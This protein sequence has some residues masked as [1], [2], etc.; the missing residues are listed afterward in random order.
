MGPTRRRPPSSW[1]RKSS[2]RATG[3]P[4]ARSRAPEARSRAPEARRVRRAAGVQGGGTARRRS[5]RGSSEGTARGLEATAVRLY[6]CSAQADE[7]QVVSRGR[8]AKAGEEERTGRRTGGWPPV[9]RRQLARRTLLVYLLERR[10]RQSVRVRMRPGRRRRRRRLRLVR[11]DAYDGGSVLVVAS[12]LAARTRRRRRRARRGRRR[13]RRV[14]PAA[15]R[16]GVAQARRLP[17]WSPCRRRRRRGAEVGLEPSPGLARRR[18]IDLK[19]PVDGRVRPRK[20]RRA[21]RSAR[22]GRHR[23][24]RHGR[25]GRR[26]P[27]R[28]GPA[29]RAPE[30]GDGVLVER[31]RAV[32]GRARRGWAE[33]E[34]RRGRNG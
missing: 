15:A 26:R 7:R 34:G 19:Q 8:L 29:D 3:R 32:C 30:L 17:L 22:D 33:R 20:R 13:A 27:P 9:G 16:L 12:G 4:R 23:P 14:G 31:R 6:V 28:G 1:P 21:E 2:R 18:E 25:S 24:L 5:A 10:W 11:L